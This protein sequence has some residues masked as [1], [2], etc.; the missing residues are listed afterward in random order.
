LFRVAIE[1]SPIK[2]VR[3]TVKIDR[4][5]AGVVPDLKV[6]KPPV[7]PLRADPSYYFTFPALLFALGPL[8]FAPSS[9][10]ANIGKKAFT[11]ACN[12]R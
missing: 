3:D 7:R 6:F 8:R 12:L 5:V 11:G 10:A 9:L 1:F 2:P 4:K